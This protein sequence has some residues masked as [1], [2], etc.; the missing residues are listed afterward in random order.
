MGGNAMLGQLRNPFDGGDG[1]DKKGLFGYASPQ[2]STGPG[3]GGVPGGALSPGTM[4]GAT[5]PGTTPGAGTTP[6]TGAPGTTP[7]A[8][9]GAAGAGATTAGP[10]Y[11]GGLEAAATPFA[12]IGDL[13]PVSIH[14]LAA[15]TNAGVAPNPPPHPTPG[16]PLPPGSRAGAP[17]Y[18][19]ARNVKVSEN[20]S[21]RPQDRIY[22]N[23]NYYNN[24]D[25]TIN[26]RDL[27]P[28]TQMKAYTYLFGVE[29]TFNDGKGSIGFRVP[30]DNLTANSNQNVF[31]STPTSTAAGNLTVIGKYILEQNLRTGSLVSAGFAITAPTGPSRFAGA[32]YLFPLNSVYFQPYLGYIYNYNRW[33]LQGFSGF[34]FTSN[35]KDVSYVFNDIGIGYYLLRDNDPNAFLSAV[36]PTFELHVNNP[37]NHRNPFNRFDLAGMPDSVDLTFGLNFQFRHAAVL[38]FAYVTPLASPKPFDAEAVVMLNL[39]YGRTR[40]G[41]I[42]ITPPPA[43]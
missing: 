18:A 33:Y 38:T 40:A 7:P 8:G 29:K 22:F 14:A 32:P 31:L 26:R 19:A 36:A 24:L 34:N 1:H 10:G 25:D 42:P 2:Y 6:G 5:T 11:G 28:V 37:I 13:S 41:L 30:L 4:A 27:S 20:Q 16:P 23:F 43:L 15:T 39:F 12:M 21:P 17:P 35:L 9:G 3:M